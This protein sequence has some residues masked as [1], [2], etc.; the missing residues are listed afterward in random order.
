M[1]TESNEGETRIVATEH[2]DPN[3]SVVRSGIAL[4]DATLKALERA[5]S[6]TISLKGLK[7]ASSSYFNVFLRRIEED[8]GLAEI[9]QHIHLEFGSKL[10]EMVF[11]R[12]FDSR[13]PR[14]PPAQ[15]PAPTSTEPPRPIWQRMLAIFGG[16]HA[17]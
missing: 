14:Q 6:V 11:Q 3:G 13:A 7:G 10:Q 12:S 1:N 17:N 8:G 9:G 16:R 5:S 15:S 4:A 2:V